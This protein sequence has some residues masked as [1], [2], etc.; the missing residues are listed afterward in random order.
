MAI[1]C[2]PAGLVGFIVFAVF[3]RLGAGIYGSAIGA[4]CAAL[5]LLAVQELSP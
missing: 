2:V 3:D 5:V 1:A 4:A